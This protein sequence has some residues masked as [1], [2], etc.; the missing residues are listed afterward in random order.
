[1][2]Q[3][4]TLQSQYLAQ[5]EADLDRTGKDKERI[6]AEIAA[7]Q[8]QLTALEHDHTLLLAVRDSL[9]AALPAT[10]PTPAPAPASA[11]GK[12]AGK[13][14]AAAVPRARKAGSSAPTAKPAAEN[15]A[16]KTAAAKNTPAKKTAAPTLRDLVLAHLGTQSE[17]RSA[18][19]VSTELEQAHPERKIQITVVRNTL[20]A[21]VAKT[22]AARTR[23]NRSVYYTAVTP[24]PAAPSEQTT[25]S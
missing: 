1:M 6:A 8:E 7:L 18:A 5:V 21:L 16:T 13:R 22:H 10:A 4:P 14:A 12:A 24:A 23:Q 17:P 20:E 9:T 2:A 15:T 25:G 3:T 19:E 11:K